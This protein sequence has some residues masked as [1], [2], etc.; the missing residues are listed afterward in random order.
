MRIADIGSITTSPGEFAAALRQCGYA[1]TVAQPDPG[2]VEVRAELAD[3]LRLSV[4]YDARTCRA[5][6]AAATTAGQPPLS[7]ARPSDVEDLVLATTS[8]QCPPCW[9]AFAAWFQPAQPRRRT[10]TQP[11]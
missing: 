7:T 6:S 8:C 5:R 2:T 4:V 11:R 9:R 3:R 10:L 1:V